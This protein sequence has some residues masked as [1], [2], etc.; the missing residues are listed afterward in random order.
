MGLIALGY[1]FIWP[2]LPI[3]GASQGYT[4]TA[5]VLLTILMGLCLVAVLL[6]VQSDAVNTKFI[7]LLGVLVA[8]NA[9]L[10]FAEVAIP[11]PGGFSP[12]FFLI[13]LTGYVYGGRFGFLMGALTLLISALITGGVGPWLPYQMLTAGW[14][15]LSVPICR[16]LIRGLQLVGQTVSLSPQSP[17]SQLVGQTVSLSPKS[18][19]EIIILAIWGA[20]WGLLY[21]VI[22]NLASWPFI[23]GLQAQTLGAEGSALAILKR[24]ATFYIATSLVWDLARAIGNTAMILAFGA[25]TLRTLRRFRRRF[26]FVYREGKGE[27]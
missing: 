10:R 20:G 11:G 22:M 16:W 7:A 17:G 18:P 13:I 8:I 26:T 2:N 27:G 21:G 1:P 12:I 14:V 3:A 23:S 19:F 25:P 15:G 4:N 6:E 9:V 5:P 24:Y